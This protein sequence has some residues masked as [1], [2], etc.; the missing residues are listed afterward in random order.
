MFPSRRGCG[1]TYGTLKILPTKPLIR[2][3]VPV[4]AFL[5]CLRVTQDTS[6]RCFV[7][8]SWRGCPS[9]TNRVSRDMRNRITSHDMKHAFLC[10]LH[11]LTNR[12]IWLEKTFWGFQISIITCLVP[13][14]KGKR[15][16]SENSRQNIFHRLMCWP[17]CKWLRWLSMLLPVIEIL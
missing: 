17:V 5:L 3:D 11:Q 1:M 9:D 13:K 7:G 12:H 6:C 4:C 15:E 10:F 2:P 14:H 16:I 8:E